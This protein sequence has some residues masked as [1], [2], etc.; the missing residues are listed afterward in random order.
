MVIKY[1]LPVFITLSRIIFTIALVAS[2]NYIVNKGLLLLIFLIIAMTDFLD[3]FLARRLNQVTEFGAVLD[4]IAD[5]FF[6]LSILILC[7]NKGYFEFWPVL[8]VALRD[9]I[10]VC[11]SVVIYINK[12]DL[13]V[14]TSFAGKL[15]TVLQVVVLFFGIYELFYDLNFKAPLFI[16]LIMWSAALTSVISG[17]QYVRY[18]LAEYKK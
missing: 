9:V 11:G 4:P 15:S 7:S 2:F 12:G 3:G 17:I 18:G 1:N 16:D 8:I 10:I 14:R 13:K 5:K 6:I